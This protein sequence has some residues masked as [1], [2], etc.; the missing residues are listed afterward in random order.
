M[1]TTSAAKTKSLNRSKNIHPSSFFVLLFGIAILALR[2]SSWSLGIISAFNQPIYAS[3]SQ[4]ESRE[5]VPKRV[6]K[7]DLFDNQNSDLAI[8]EIIRQS[9]VIVNFL[10]ENEHTLLI[11]DNSKSYVT[12]HSSGEIIAEYG[13]QNNRQSQRPD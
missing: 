5:S 11:V 9:I 13:R 6:A 2:H 10:A 8:T 1:G 12:K 3:R 4:P 7:L